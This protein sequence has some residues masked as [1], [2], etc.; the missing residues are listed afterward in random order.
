MPL[1]LAGVDLTT[2]TV[3]T[4]RLLLRPPEDRDVDPITRAC[5]DPH[6]Q[7]WLSTLPSPTRGRTV[8]FVTGVAP[9]GRASGT[10]VPFAVEADG[11]LVGMCG[12]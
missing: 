12:L 9:R 11:G 2:G 6:N 4:E 1:D 10:D 7:R 5:Q 3:R 8:E